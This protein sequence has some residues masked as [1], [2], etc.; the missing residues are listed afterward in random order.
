MY[1]LCVNPFLPL[2][3]HDNYYFCFTVEETE[4]QEVQVSKTQFLSDSKCRLGA[5]PKLLRHVSAHWENSN[6]VEKPVVILKY[7]YIY[8]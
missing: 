8:V 6:L 3:S 1:F 4:A 2:N 7:I 5:S